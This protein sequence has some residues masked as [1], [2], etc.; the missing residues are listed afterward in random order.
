MV[1]PE[2]VTV[3]AILFD[4]DGTLIDSTPGVISAWKTFA[5]EYKLGSHLPIVQ[6]THGRRLADT[7]KDE[8]ICNIQDTEILN[9]EILRFEDLVIQGSPVALEG[10]IEFLTQCKIPVPTSGF[11]TADDVSEGKPKPTPYLEGAKK[12]GVDVTKCLVIEDAPSG[13]QAGNSAGAKTLAVCTSHKREDFENCSE[14]IKRPTY[15]IDDLTT[16]RVNWENGKIRLAIDTRRGPDGSAI[17]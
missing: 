6:K 17:L 12:L 3:D 10:A 5:E 13:V 16:V 8:T 15:I 4:L 7:L 9:S 2:I 14:E 1:L 11:V